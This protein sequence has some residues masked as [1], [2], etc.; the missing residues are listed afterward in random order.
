MG[1]SLTRG[2]PGR[3]IWLAAGHA[4]SGYYR[5]HLLLT[6][7]QIG[8]GIGSHRLSWFHPGEHLLFSVR[9][10]GRKWTG[11]LGTLHIR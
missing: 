3:G 7:R 5:F 8:I 10:A 2:R 1:I 6:T 11:R 9:Y 4:K